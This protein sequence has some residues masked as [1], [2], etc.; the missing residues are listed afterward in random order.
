MK[1][2]VMNWLVFV[3][4]LTA[5][6]GSFGSYKN[7]Y[8]S[9]FFPLQ[10]DVL[11]AINKHN[12]VLMDQIKAYSKSHTVAPIN[13]RIDPVWKAIPGYNGKTVNVNAS[14]N[15]MKEANKFDPTKIVYKE[16]SPQV[17]LS[18]LSFQ[19]V[20]RGNPNKPMVSLIFNVTQGNEYIPQ[21]LKTL[22]QYN[23]KATFFL[24]G[25]WVKE[26]PRLAMMISEEGHAIGNH[27]Y[28][29]VDLKK[30]TK[31]E[32]QSQLQKANTTIEAI[33]D[34]Q[35]HYFSPPSGSFNQQTLETTQSL[36]LRTVMW[37]VDS[38][39]WKHPD[40]NLMVQKVSEKVEA[41][42]II[43]FH[44]TKETAE[45]LGPI[46]ESIKEKGYQLGT[47]PDLVSEERVGD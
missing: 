36:N 15:N 39:D 44:S 10:T 7:L 6:F 27:A 34:T 30:L 23:V 32:T 16:I 9:Q 18:D 8:L 41:G 28:T 37:S 5:T 4:L 11:P 24:D 21:I 33:L 19:P 13:A 29:H 46:I 3:C 42:S 1:R 38:L 17:H 2:T 25:S 40:P 22:N 14:F 45:G 47:I 31:Q 26:N 12:D 35:P 43:L 20:Y